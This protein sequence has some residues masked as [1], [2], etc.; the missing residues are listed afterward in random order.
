MKTLQI[1][2]IDELGTALRH[3][4]AIADVL[5]NANDD[6]FAESTAHTCA[7][8]IFQ[9]AT[10]SIEALEGKTEPAAQS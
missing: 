1:D 7:D 9:I 4:A 10:R 3:I 2:Q 8:L 6:L 5:A